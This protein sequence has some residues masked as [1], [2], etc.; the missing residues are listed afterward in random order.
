MTRKDYNDIAE[1]IAR[2]PVE[3]AAAGDTVRAAAN[4]IADV[5]A[6]DNPNFDRARFLAACNVA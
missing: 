5:C 1:A 4:T 3:S 6:A 2:L